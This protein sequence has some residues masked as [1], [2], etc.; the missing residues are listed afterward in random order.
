MYPPK[1]TDC[2][3]FG[4][5]LVAPDTVAVDVTAQTLSSFYFSWKLDFST[6]NSTFSTIEIP[7]F[8]IKTRFFQLAI[9][10]FHVSVCT[11]LD[12]VSVCTALDNVSVCT[13]YCDVYYYSVQFRVKMLTIKLTEST[14]ELK[15]SCSISWSRI[16]SWK[17]DFSR[18]NII[19]SSYVIKQ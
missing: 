16:P 2:F 15:K 11:A 3:I 14:F 9:M 8:K 17:I 7:F 4:R 10:F 6:R 5:Y 18:K 19:A 1:S 12:N 13:I